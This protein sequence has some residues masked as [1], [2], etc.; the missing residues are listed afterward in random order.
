MVRKNWGIYGFLG[1]SWVLI[2]Y[3]TCPPVLPNIYTYNTSHMTMPRGDWRFTIL[4]GLYY[5]L[6][7][8]A[9]RCWIWVF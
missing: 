8:C 4:G 7:R 6:L 1:T 5:Y 9:I 3:D 2:S